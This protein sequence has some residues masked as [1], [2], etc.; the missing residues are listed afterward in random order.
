[1]RPHEL[2]SV[3][4]FFAL[5]TDEEEPAG[6]G[7]YLAPGREAVGIRVETVGRRM[8]TEDRRVA[9][10]VAFQGIAGRLLSIGLGAVVLTGEVPDLRSGRLRWQ[11]TL[12]APD[13]LW[14]PGPVPAVPAE[15]L[16]DVVLDGRLVPLLGLMRDVVPVSPRLMRGNAG[17]AL[18]GALRVLHGWCRER[19]RAADAERAL[20]VA[21][22]LF[23]HP[24][25]T[26][27]GELTV[28]AGG[29]VFVRDTCCLYYRV[30]AGAGMCGD[31]VLRH[32]PR[33][34]T[35]GIR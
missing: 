4:P 8:G 29:P 24:L 12:T 3:G 10:S 34:R 11:P 18:A 5:R 19:G 23:R 17:S 6:A 30:P 26:G 14:L 7:G 28:T 20:A 22:G 2:A 9:A 33:S 35:P 16:A 13:D 21:R 15:R 27:T 25:L 1:M 32:P 31:C